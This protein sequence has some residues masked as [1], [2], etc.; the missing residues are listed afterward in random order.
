MIPL[1]TGRQSRRVNAL[2][3]RLC[4]N[5]YGGG[6]IMLGCGCP[7]MISLSLLCKYFRHAVLPADMRLEAD[8]LKTHPDRCVICGVPIVRRSNRQKYC[9]ECSLKAFREQQAKYAKKRR[10]ESKFGQ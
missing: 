4:A 6:C 2:I 5:Y 7:Q 10:D 8:I 9:R 1:M 3:K